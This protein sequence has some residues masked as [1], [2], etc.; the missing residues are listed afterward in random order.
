LYPTGK[1]IKIFWAE[2][3]HSQTK[4]WLTKLSDIL[5]NK[6]SL[7]TLKGFLFFKMS[8]EIGKGWLKRIGWNSNAQTD[9]AKICKTIRMVVNIFLNIIRPHKAIEH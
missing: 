4:G 5:K 8:D 6:K 1:L 9:W 2:L 3:L 7:D